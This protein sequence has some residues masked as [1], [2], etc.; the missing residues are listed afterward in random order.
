MGDAINVTTDIPGPRSAAVL[1]RKQ[2][3]VCDPLD[4]HVPAVI[5]SA[6]GARFTDIDGNQMLDF[7]AGLGCQ[8]VGYSHP[9]VVEAVQRQA[10][11]VSHTDF[12][13]IP[14]EPFVQLAEGLVERVGIPGAK[15]AM[16]N[17]GAEAIENAVKFARAATGRPAIISFEGAFHGRT[18]LTMSLTSRH[19]PYK[20]GFGPFAPETYRL[21]YAYPYRSPD[22][23][24]AARDALDAFERAFITVVDP[25]AVAAV[26]VEPIQGEGGFVVPPAEF[27]Q[28]IREAC[29]R[30]GIVVI[31]DEVQTGTGRTG[32]FLASEQFGFRPDVV[33]LA[34]ALASG[35]P[36][37]AVVGRPEIM[38]APGPSAIG[39]T[40]VGNPVACAAA[41]AVL[42]VIDDEGLLQRSEEIGKVVRARWEQIAADVPEVGE[43]RGVGAMVG[44]E[45]V[46]D[47]E[48]KEP[49]PGYLDAVLRE[50]ISRG[51]VTVGCGLYHNVLRHLIPLV[52]S[53]DDLEEGLDV[54]AA[55]AVAAR[56]SRAISERAAEVEGS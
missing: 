32:T 55:S 47:R 45:F 29:T 52:I 13:V 23:D 33:V 5:D 38:D 46:R 6:L 39:G 54:L 22:P 19:K 30:H 17:S 7:S 37:S 4:I 36:L 9:R 20:T 31:A 2:K 24:R 51:L 16:F 28:G 49:A 50:S 48:T 53:D 56:R 42:Q 40:Y 21:P 1:E 25:K 15:V 41:N 3:V 35:Y 14:Y 26:I 44:V 10:A 8:L 12:S 11:K 43:I 18:L 34:K 27:L